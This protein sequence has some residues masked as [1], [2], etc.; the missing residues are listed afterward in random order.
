MYVRLKLTKRQLSS[1]SNSPDGAEVERGA[2]AVG[3][4]V[5]V[6]LV[7]EERNIVVQ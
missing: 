4:L 2:D 3:A 7:S 6:L 1:N 5:V